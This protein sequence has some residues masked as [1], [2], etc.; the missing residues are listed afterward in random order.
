M[1]DETDDPRTVATARLQ[2][3]AKDFAGPEIKRVA[4]RVIS[5]LRSS[6]PVEMFGD[7]AARHMWDEYS[8]DTQEGPFV[9][10]WE[11]TVREMVVA[12]LDALPKYV[13]FALS[14]YAS[15]DGLDDGE[16][17]SFCHIAIDEIARDVMEVINMRASERH[18]DLIGPH[19]ADVIPCEVEGH[20]VVWDA[21]SD[22]D[23][24]TDLIST[25][26]DVMIE[27]KA[28]LSGLAVELA[29]AFIAA[30]RE[31]AE[32]CISGMLDGYEVEIKKL[33]IEKDV[34]PA[35]S[36]MREAILGRLDEGE[37]QAG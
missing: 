11:E 17:K 7:V 37:E 34:L 20:G 13:L 26:A 18:I 3:V 16:C 10:G 12:E 31:E 35:L 21:L 15:A 22:R 36:S 27:A 5:F 29:D 24:A 25:Y 33:L 4:E 2:S 6:S 32:G 8:Y 28:D 14:A 23:E 19:R 9:D 30:A 1:K